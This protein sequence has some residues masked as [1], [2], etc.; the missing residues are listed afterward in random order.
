MLH[1]IAQ[2]A[3]VVNILYKTAQ[4]YKSHYS[5]PSQKT[6]LKILSEIYSISRSIST[7]NRWLR[8]LEDD[9]LFKRRRRIR[10]MPNKQIYFRSTMYFIRKKG[11]LW[12]NRLGYDVWAVLSVWYEKSKRARDLATA[13]RI[14]EKE[15]KMTYAEYIKSLES[16]EGSSADEI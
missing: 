8:R 7:L 15:K 6:I 2:Y 5:Y 13:G 10:R 9:N 16:E 4:K 12:L 11:M 1:D 3:P 14:K